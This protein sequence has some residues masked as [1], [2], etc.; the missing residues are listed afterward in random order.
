MLLLAAVV[1]AASPSQPAQTSGGASVQ[2]TAMIR[3]VSGVQV[4]FSREPSEGDVPP[5]RMTV[6]RTADAQQQ[7]AK[8]IEFQ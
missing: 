8:L 3:V 6:I 1:I 5:P 2:A 7:P 4:S